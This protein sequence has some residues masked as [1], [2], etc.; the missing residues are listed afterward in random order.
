M[1][2]EVFKTGESKTQEPWVVE[3]AELDLQAALRQE[4]R[5]PVDET[6]LPQLAPLK[7]DEEPDSSDE[8][9]DSA[10]QASRQSDDDDE[11]VNDLTK[12]PMTYSLDRD[13]D[14]YLGVD[15]PET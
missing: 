2:F 1:E 15:T 6:K 7:F 9:H 3:M 14:R 4:E 5:V 8:D 12:A 10:S 13:Q 11:F